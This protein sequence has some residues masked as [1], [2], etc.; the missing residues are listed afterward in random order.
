MSYNMKDDN[1]M[2]IRDPDPFIKF[3]TDASGSYV[4]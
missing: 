1:N 2:C 3:V 4:L